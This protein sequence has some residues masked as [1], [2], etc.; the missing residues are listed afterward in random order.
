LDFRELGLNL[1]GISRDSPYS[2][3]GWGVNLG[4]NFPLLSDWNGDAVRAFGVAQ[5]VDGMKD[6][7]VRSVFIANAAGVIRFA[8]AYGDD[9]APVADDLLE[10]AREIGPFGDPL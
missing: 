3:K 1:A 2:H 5:V 10:A 4:V 9:E 8:R 7:P 6:V